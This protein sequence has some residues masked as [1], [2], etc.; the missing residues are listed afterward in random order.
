MMVP[1][2]LARKSFFLFLA[3]T[4]TALL[5][6]LDQSIGAEGMIVAVDQST[7]LKAIG[8]GMIA[9]LAEIWRGQ[10]SLYRITGKQGEDIKE[11][12]GFCKGKNKSC[13]TST[14]E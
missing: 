7:L 3:I 14:E 12:K 5:L 6:S 10:R 8:L 11:L 2:E 4:A 9:L 1:V 13:G